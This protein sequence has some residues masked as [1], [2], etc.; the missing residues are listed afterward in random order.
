MR[1]VAQGRRGPFVSTSREDRLA[2]GLSPTTFGLSAPSAPASVINK[3]IPVP[4]V[5]R[6]PLQ[7]WHHGS[8]KK[9]LALG[10]LGAGA[11]GAVAG[12]VFGNR[13]GTWHGAIRGTAGGALGGAVTSAALGMGMPAMAR[14]AMKNRNVM[15]AAGSYSTNIIKLSNGLNT[16]SARSGLFATGGMLGG[17][18]GGGASSKKR[19]F[20]KDRGSRISY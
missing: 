18:F 1:T 19:G 6:P 7:S 17:V 15:E 13:D 9:S 2:G 8:S 16:A 14:M 10:V 20:N 5:S 4:K 12:G 3:S 11:V